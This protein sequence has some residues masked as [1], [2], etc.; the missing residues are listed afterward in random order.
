MSTK[1]HRM[2]KATLF[3]IT[4]NWGSVKR[5]NQQDTREQQKPTLTHETTWMSL[6]KHTE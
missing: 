4:P 5:L 3:I 6:K 1:A 2:C